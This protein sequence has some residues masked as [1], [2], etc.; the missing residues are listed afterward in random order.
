MPVS[1][2]A[3]TSFHFYFPAGLRALRRFEPLL[4]TVPFGAQVLRRRQKAV[5]SNVPPRRRLR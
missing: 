2:S 3:S 5:R 1:R 4:A